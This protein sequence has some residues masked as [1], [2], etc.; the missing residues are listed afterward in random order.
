MATVQDESFYTKEEYRKGIRFDIGSTERVRRLNAMLHSLPHTICLHRARAYTEVFSKTE[1]ATPVARFATAFARTLKDLPPVIAEGE[2]LVGTAACRLRSVPVI[3]EAQGAWLRNDIESLPHRQW[4]PF[5]VSSEQ[6]EEV[7]EILSYWKGKTLLDLALKAC[8]PDLDLTGMAQGTGWANS[9]ASLFTNGYHFTPP[10]ELILGKGMKWY[11]DRCKEAL[12]LVKAGDPSPVS[13]RDF[14]QALLMIVSAIKEFAHRYAE[15]ALNLSEKEK[16]P[17]RKKEL[18][19]ISEIVERVPYHGA[20]SFREAMQGVWFV[21]ALLHIEGTGP[22]YTLGRLDQYLYPYYKADL[23][24]GVLRPQEAQELIECLFIKVTGTLWLN[25]NQMARRSPGYKQSQTV[26]IGGVDALGRDAS[27]E[28]SYLCL[29]AAKSVR[30]IQPDIALLCHP[31]ETPY[32]LKMKASE[33]TMLGLGLPK[34]MSTE[35]IKSQLMEVG[36]SLEEAKLG[37]IQ[38]CTEPYGPGCKQYGHSGGSSLNLPMA[39][40]AVLFN[41]RKRMPGQL[42]SGERV[43]V[44]TGDCCRFET[45]DDFMGAVKT[46]IAKQIR[47]GHRASC[48]AESVRMEHFPVLFQSLFTEGCIERGVPA[49]AGGAR[50][51]VG[52]GISLTG[53]VGTIADSLA[54]IKKL[55]FEEKRISMEEL[56]KAIDANFRGHETVKKMLI[57]EAPKFGNDV[58]YVDDIA[59]EIFH[60]ANSE[61]RKHITPLGNRNAPAT[62]VPMSNLSAGSLTWATPDGREAGATLSNH[63]GPTSQRDANGPTAHINSVTKLGLDEQWGNIHNLYLVNIDNDE[64][65]HRMIDLIDLFHGR[66]GHHVQINCQDKKVFMD[67]Q[68]HPEQY[69]T[70]MVRVAGYVAYFVDLPKELQDEIIARTSLRV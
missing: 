65:M 61:V 43:G 12:A 4:D 70:L 26:S 52:P 2:L 47:D 24:K 3:P 30:T 38:G 51:N 44:E 64:K 21:N 17:I 41:G 11:E 14:Y 55:V 7:K 15:T 63:V 20:R 1:G 67:A 58:D 10:Y 54:A 56:L 46:Q 59:R 68:Q 16:D 8:P 18:I 6:V 27:N 23:E 40:E 35:T 62:C 31:R 36:Y 49:N 19:E 33:L 34:F 66:G 5:K 45:F 25:S 57:D 53:G 9:A 32:R 28:L 37:W 60:F 39:L 29:E 69:P 42:R 48:C 22:V 50:I 13:K